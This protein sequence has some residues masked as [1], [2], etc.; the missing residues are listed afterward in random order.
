MLKSVVVHDIAINHIAPMERWYYRDHA[1]EINRRFGPWLTRHDS[2][3]P[4]DAPA[5]ARE[6]GFYNWRVTEGYWR[7]MPATGPRGNLAFTLPP[8][9]PRVAT[10]FLPAQPTE[11]YLGG[12]LQPH[13]RAV[14]RWYVLHRFP[15]G[16]SERDAESWFEDAHARQLKAL[17]GVYR[18]FS[19]RAV[20]EPT[21]LPGEW[22]PS[23]RPH[24]GNVLMQWDRL[25]ELWFENFDDWRAF[26]SA[27]RR[28]L[29]P[30]WATH[31][32]YPF[33]RPHQE[34]VSSF[35]LER[36]TD[37]FWRDARGYL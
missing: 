36:P 32:E 15:T 9:E 8:A 7:E 2:Y 1:P 5:D 4:V 11:D 26:R 16:V 17:P 24:A 31:A 18:A 23:A 34:L 10:A 14:L 22:P 3:L 21:G 33:V 27:A 37:E 28:S 20:R 6:A 25:T 13:E 19:T 29:R 35:L 30:G 12:H